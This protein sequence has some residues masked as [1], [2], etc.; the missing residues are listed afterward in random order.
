MGEPAGKFGEQSHVGQSLGNLRLA[1]LLG[2]VVAAG[3][4][5]LT[6]DIAHL[7]PFVQ[8]GHGVL[9]DHLDP[10]GDLLIQGLGDAA[11][12]LLAVKQDF[13]AGGGVDADDGT[14]D[15][16]LTGAGLAHQTE[17]FTLIDVE[18]D[19]IHRGEGMAAGAKADGEVL[20][21]HQLLSFFSQRGSLLSPA[22]RG[23][24]PAAP[25]WEPGDP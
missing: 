4:Q 14:A 6:D 15:G 7:G 3:V 12:D 23:R 24:A 25:P 13:A 21:L 22:E 5:S 9:E 18:G 10:P 8:R 20:N 1:F 11:V 19:L 16:G 17:G 2:Q